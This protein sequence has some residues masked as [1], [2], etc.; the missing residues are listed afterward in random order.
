MKEVV[1]KNCCLCTRQI[2]GSMSS[3][4]FI[5]IKDGLGLYDCQLGQPAV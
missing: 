3:S 5:T 1:E 2:G 4:Y